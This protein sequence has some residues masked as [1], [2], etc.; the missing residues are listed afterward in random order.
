[1]D[2][3]ISPTFVQPSNHKFSA[4]M[5]ECNGVLTNINELERADYEDFLHTMVCL[6]FFYKSLNRPAQ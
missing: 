5:V 2:D 4:V 3:L 6:I 1:M